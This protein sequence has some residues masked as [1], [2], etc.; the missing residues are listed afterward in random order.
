MIF[1]LTQYAQSRVRL[2][3]TLYPQL[4]PSINQ[5]GEAVTFSVLLA[6]CDTAPRNQMRPL[7]LLLHSL[8]AQYKDPAGAWLAASLRSSE[9][10]SEPSW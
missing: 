3:Q 9:L 6:L 7:G 2:V 1:F 10:Q 5:Q 4:R 8:L